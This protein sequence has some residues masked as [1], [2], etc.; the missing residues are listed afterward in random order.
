LPDHT[1]ELHFVC[2][3]PDGSML[4]GGSDDGIVRLWNAHTGKVLATVQAHNGF[5][6][7]I[8]FSADNRFLAS[9]GD[10]TVYLWDIV[11]I[12]AREADDLSG[13]Q[14]R[15]YPHQPVVRLQPNIGRIIHF[16]FSPER[17]KL[18][19]VDADGT[20]HSWQLAHEQGLDKDTML[21]S[22]QQIQLST[23]APIY[24][25]C[26]SPNGR[27]IA[28]ASHDIR[29]WDF[30]TG[31]MLVTLAGHMGV[32]EGICFSPD[33]QLLAS[34]S[35][36]GTIKLWDVRTGACLKTVRADRPYERMN[37]SGVTGLT[38]AQRAKLIALGAV[39]DKT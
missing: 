4:A 10:Q 29:L 26:L 35:E 36:D 32:I 8:C 17:Y 13:E 37:I 6:G 21:N 5:L 20:I 34:G 16:Y 22:H 23:E 7:D 25:A 39:E 18:I 24:F 27:I 19:G 9:S 2:V 30:D 1:G 31:T 11:D 28:G 12:V 3:S 33:S 38:E 15:L 14:R